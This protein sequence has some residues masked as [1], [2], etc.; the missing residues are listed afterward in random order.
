[1]AIKKI[2]IY[3]TLHFLVPVIFVI[4]FLDINIIRKLLKIQIGNVVFDSSITM[5]L[6]LSVLLF[7]FSLNRSLIIRNSNYTRIFIAKILLEIVLILGYILSYQYNYY[8]VPVF[9]SIV[10]PINCALLWLFFTKLYILDVSRITSIGITYFSI[11]C[12]IVVIYNLIFF[13]FGVDTARLLSPGGG[14][15]IFGY[16]IALVFALYCAIKKSSG[17]KVGYF[18]PAILIITSLLSG[19][20]GSIWTIIIIV[21]FYFIKSRSISIIKKITIINIVIIFAL[22][23]NEFMYLFPRITM[24]TDNSRLNTLINGIR[25]FFTSNFIEFFLG[26]GLTT[27][28][29]YQEWLINKTNSSLFSF[30]NLVL[31]DNIYILVQPHNTY[32]YLLLE[33]GLIGLSIYIYILIQL[34]NGVK[35]HTYY[36]IVFFVFVILN[37]FD[38]VLLIEPVVSTFWLIILM[39]I[40]EISKKKGKLEYEENNGSYRNQA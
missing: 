1:M 29:P 19:S 17:K 30:Y 15:V 13:G 26:R 7:I 12:I 39:I 24:F 37:I 40:N 20:R 25:I 34:Y 2:D 36:K 9:L 27:V 6:I 35:T 14:P 11:F 8:F 10:L 33:C 28:F 21:S 31:I 38:S 23:L 16:T 4:P 3:S 5:V 32:L 18:I 22:L